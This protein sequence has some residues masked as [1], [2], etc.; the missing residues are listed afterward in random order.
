[1]PEPVLQALF[2]SQLVQRSH[3]TK[4]L[5]VEREPNNENRTSILAASD[6]AHGADDTMSISVEKYPGNSVQNYPGG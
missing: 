5:E 3:G 6:A 4:S 1:M 2:M